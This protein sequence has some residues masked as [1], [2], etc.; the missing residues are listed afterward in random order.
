MHVPKLTFFIAKYF[1]SGVIIATAFIHLLAPAHEALGSPCLQDYP[2]AE[3]PWVEGI[4]LMTIFSMFFIELMANRYEVF[5]GAGHHDA[6]HLHDPA[7]DL[8]RK[9]P[10]DDDKSSE[11][12]KSGE[13]RR[14]TASRT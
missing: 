7:M 11:N 3:Y 14:T 12:E 10:T 6:E 5:S 2:I 8:V 4:A 9:T 1:G 13:L